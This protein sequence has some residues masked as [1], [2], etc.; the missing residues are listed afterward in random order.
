M[1]R[2]ISPRLGRRNVMLNSFAGSISN[3]S[4]EFSWTPEMSISEIISQPRMFAQK[5]KGGISF[6]QL[7]CTAD[8][9]CW[10]Q[11]N[12]QMDMV[13]SNMQ[14]IDVAAMTIGCFSDKTF[15]INFNSKKFERIPSIFGLPN[16]MECVLPEGMTKGLQIHFFPPESAVRNKAHAN[17]K[18]V[19]REGNISPLCNNQSV[20]EFKM[21][22]GAPPWLKSEGIRASVM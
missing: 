14:L 13:N 9:H 2:Q 10:R 20:Q 22:D 1:L 17:S 15:T 16:K 19:C 21:E 4:E 7:K 6:K 11:L 12:K 3:T 18:L 5:F 8:R